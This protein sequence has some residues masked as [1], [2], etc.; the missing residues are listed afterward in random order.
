MIQFNIITEE[1][2]IKMAILEADE[3]K[4]F[5]AIR[6]IDE[7]SNEF[8]YARDLQEV[9]QYTKW[10]N[11]SRVIDKAMLA[12]KNSGINVNDHFPEARKT[13]KMPKTAEK[14]IIDTVAIFYKPMN[15][16]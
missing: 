6:Q 2:K 16:T 15:F 14:E 1:E 5:E 7:N 13:I 11:F 4:T 10:E 3:Y 8:W 9:L 12:C